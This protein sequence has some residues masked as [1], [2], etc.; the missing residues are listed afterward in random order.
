MEYYSLFTDGGAR[1]NPGPAAGAAFLYDSRQ[2]QVEAAGEY[3]GIASN[4]V[5]EY[6]ALLIG[7]DLALKHEVTHLR[8]NL[9]SELVVKQLRRE[10]KVK[11][12]DMKILFVKAQAL[13][14]K[15]ASIEFIHVP[16]ELNKEADQKVNEIL[17]E[18]LASVVS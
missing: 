7:L 17:D 8:C 1:G 16:R 5:A 2:E 3:L 4:N 9:D 10:Y 6:K 11:H 14:S 15:F 12:P 13:I 18:R